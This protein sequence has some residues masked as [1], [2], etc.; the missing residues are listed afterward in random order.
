MRIQTLLVVLRGKKRAVVLR[1]QSVGGSVPF[2][3]LSHPRSQFA[4]RVS[5]VLCFREH[6]VTSVLSAS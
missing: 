5:P 4:P 6:L 1:H 3:S 2:V